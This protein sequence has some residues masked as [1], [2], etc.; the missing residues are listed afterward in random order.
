MLNPEVVVT[1][2]VPDPD[3]KLGGYRYEGLETFGPRRDNINK[4]LSTQH[5]GGRVVEESMSRDSI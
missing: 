3:T 1:L 5:G 2:Y 4:C